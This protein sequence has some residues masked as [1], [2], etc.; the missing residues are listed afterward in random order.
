MLVLL[1]EA[2][3]GL[4]GRG[5][6]GGVWRWLLE[7]MIST[8]CGGRRRVIDINRRLVVEWCVIRWGLL[9]MAHRRR[10]SSGGI[11]VHWGWLMLNDRWLLV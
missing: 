1:I 4:W 7:L 6:V 9:V 8:S 2:C 11:I 10:R 5:H 3:S